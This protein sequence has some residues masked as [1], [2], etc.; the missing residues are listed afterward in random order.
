M[1]APFLQIEVDGVQRSRR[2]ARAN[3]K[4]EDVIGEI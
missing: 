3:L 4:S 2:V 1:R